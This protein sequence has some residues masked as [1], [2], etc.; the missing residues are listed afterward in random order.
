[1]VHFISFHVNCAE[2]SGRAEVLAG[3]AADAFV[4]VHSRHLY[5]AIWAFVIHHL[6]SSSGAMSCTVAAADAVGQHHAV[7][8]DP[9]GMTHMDV[10]LFLTGDGLDGTGR[11]D[12]AAAGA[13]GATVAALKRHHRL[14]E[15]H[16]IGGRTQ[17]VIWTQ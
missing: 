14:H 10:G 11:A 8:L 2:R 13:F 3:T 12:L 1:M 4:L 17:D 9:N 7:L 6:D 5:L 15:V 16:Q